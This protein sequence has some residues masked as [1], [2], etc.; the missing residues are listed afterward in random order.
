M[1]RY[2]AIGS[3]GQW[4]SLAFTTIGLI[5]MLTRGAPEW[6]D[7][8]TSGALLLTIATKVR[9]YGGKYIRDKKRNNLIS[10]S[11]ILDQERNTQASKKQNYNQEAQ[12]G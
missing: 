9:Y 1:K 8:I 4:L 10:I 5:F 12:N 3:M 6:H 11:Q 2:E 7:F